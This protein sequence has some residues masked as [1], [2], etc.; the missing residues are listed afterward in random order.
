MFSDNP[1]GIPSDRTSSTKGDILVVDDVPENLQLL[2]SILTEQGYEVR[3]VI[4][5]KHALRVAHSDPP[6]LILLDIM[7]PDLDGYEVCQQ[8]KACEATREIPVIFLSALDD[9]LDKV[10]AFSVG[11]VDYITKPIHAQEVIA[12]VENQ[13]TLVRQRS[14]LREQTARLEQEIKERQ[15][16]EAALQ[17]SAIKLRN[18]NLVLTKLARS[19]ALHQGDLEAALTQI[20]QAS[21]HNLGVERASVWLLNEAGT[22]LHCLDLFEKLYNR[23]S[24]GIELAASDYPAYFQ[25]LQQDQP[26]AA[27]NA[28]TDPRTRE[29]SETY[30]TPLGI[31]SMLDTPIR[32]NG[33]TAGVICLE[34]IGTFRQ[35][36]PEDQNFAR[37]L[38]DLVSLALEARERKQAELAQQE[39]EERFRTLVSNIP[40]AVYRSLDDTNRTMGFISEAILDISGYPPS[41]FINNHVRSFSSIIH[42]DD[43]ERVE[44]IMLESLAN[45]QAF[46]IEYQLMRADG[47]IAWVSEKGRGIFDSAGELLWLDG[48]IFDISDRR[49]AEV[50]LQASVTRNR[51]IVDA[52]PDSLF[53]LSAHGT[54]LDYNAPNFDKLAVPPCVFLGKTVTEVLPPDVAALFERHIKLALTTGQVQFYEYQLTPLH[55]ILSD[56][57]A[58]IAPAGEHEVLCIVRDISDKKRAEAALRESEQ[59]FRAIFNSSFQFTAVLQPDG[60]LLDANQT[61]LDF[62]GSELSE[63]VGRP[64]W[65]A[66]WWTEPGKRKKAKGKRAKKAAELSPKQQQLKEAIARAAKGE[67]VRYEVDI[68]GAGDTTATIDFSI[69]PVFD[70]SQTVMLLVPEGRNITERKLAEGTLRQMAQREKAIAQVIQRMRQTLDLETIFTATTQELRQVIDCDRAVVYQFK[71]DGTGEFVAESVE[72][73]WI[74]LLQQQYHD[75]TFRQ[76]IIED[77]RCVVKTLRSTNS[78]VQETSIQATSYTYRRGANYLCVTDI[79]QTNFPSS[80]IHL[81][82]RFQAKAYIIVPIFCGNKLWGLLATYQNSSSRQWKTA[83]INIM[84]Q[85][86]NQLGVALQQVELLEQTQKQSAALQKAVYAA[87]AA[88]RA[89]SEFLANMSHELRTPLNAILGFTQVMSRDSSLST[90]HQQQLGIIN[91]AGEHLLDLINDVLEM[92]KIESGRIELHENCFDLIRLLESLENMLRLRAESKG[93]DLIFEITPD[94]PQFVKTDESKLRSCLINLLGNA[95]KFTSSGG[96]S[97]RVRLGTQKLA[98]DKFLSTDFGKSSP[99]SPSTHAKFLNAQCFITFEISDTGPGIAPE[100]INLLFEPFGQTQTGRNSQQGSGLGLPIARKFVQMMGGDIAVNSIVG[101]GSTFI[102]DIQTTL[103]DRTDVPTTRPKR[104]V[105]SLA[106]NQSDYR[107]LVVDDRFESRLVLLTLLTS[108]G[109]QVREADNGRDAIAQWENWQPHLIF[110]DMRMPGMGGHEATQYIKAREQESREVGT[111]VLLQN[112]HSKT[113]NWQTVIIALTA[114]AFEDERQMV[115]SAGCDDFVGK[116]FRAD[117]LLE[118]ISQHLGVVYVYEEQA[119]TPEDE[120]QKTQES[121]TFADFKRYLSQMPTQWVIQ[122]HDAAAIGSDDLVLALIEQIP[123]ENALLIT[124]LTDLTDNFEFEKIIDL[125]QPDTIVS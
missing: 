104:K 96:V 19:S 89:K 12:R 75:P 2:S 3:R 7:M 28:H 121:L 40:G 5:G 97:L 41:D 8:L 34:H 48:V 44:R 1:N 73:E 51:A 99:V 77:G 114:S 122:L 38:A 72:G 22:K 119:L 116:P 74:S 36:T 101:E 69:K 80:Y 26:L 103:V 106:P 109:F 68:R 108:I 31:A 100:E 63:L 82:E 83:E 105:M 16:A 53:C 18:H 37:S 30:L 90:K 58:R 124:A 59:R 24:C 14:V 91:R 65:E 47:S 60:T 9:P 42:P 15:R 111:S 6:E 45:K 43:R 17:E 49:Q 84:I 64:F 81:L 56:F 29:F 92:S 70:S 85:I 10:K 120:A 79:Y 125:T 86:G 21:T 54:Y 39:R 107:I 87:D 52:I 102:L 57:E 33:K 78:L 32:I 66:K 94:I 93:L 46:L 110:M 98:A 112:P 117:L 76:T 50:A 71:P 62:T 23:H 13:L 123:Q 88:N 35:W 95:I 20:T 115:L 61:A 4:N 27:E 113:L 67:T 11:G 55:G 118:K 25:A